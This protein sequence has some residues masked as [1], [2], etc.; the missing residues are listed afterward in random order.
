MGRGFGPGNTQGATKFTKGTGTKVR[1]RGVEEWGIGG[2]ELRVKNLFGPTK[3]DILPVFLTR[4]KWNF[5]E[6]FPSRSNGSLGK[7]FFLRDEARE[8]EIETTRN[9]YQ[10]IGRDAFTAGQKAK[11][12]SEE[13]GRTYVFTEELTSLNFL[14]GGVNEQKLFTLGSGEYISASKPFPS[15]QNRRGWIFNFGSRIQEAQWVPNEQGQTQYLAVAV[16][17]KQ[18]TRKYKHMENPK[19]A[20][21]VATKPFP[22]SIQIWAFDSL[23][24]G[25]LDPSVTPRLEQV[26]CTEWGA[27]KA[28]RW[29]PIGIRNTV[30]PQNDRDSVHL[31]LLAGVWSDGKLRILDVAHQ[32]IRR[33]VQETQ[34]IHYTQAAFEV[35]F[36]ETVPSCIHWLSGTSLAAATASGH[37]AIWSLSRSD[38]FLPAEK[39]TTGNLGPQPWFYRQV[40]DTYIL[41][42]SSGYPSR[43]QYISITTADGF[44][45]LIDLRSPM[46]DTCSSIRGRMLVLTQDWHEHT[47]CFVMPDE[48]Y[49]LTHH[50]IRRYYTNIY[51]MRIESTITACATS[52]VQPCVLLGGADGT[53]MGCN[54]LGKVL[55]TKEI[56]WQQPWFKHEWRPEV[57]QM[58]PGLKNSEGEIDESTTDARH[59]AVE[60]T[61]ATNPNGTVAPASPSRDVDEEPSNDT[62]ASAFSQPLVRITEGY[63]AH[64]T[65]MQYP[66]STKRYKEGAKFITIF[67]EKSA[68]SRLAWNP[69]LKFGAWA[70]AG[71]NSGLL[72]VEDLGV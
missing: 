1:Q 47:Q 24:D 27:P 3:D 65:G 32:Q 54:T 37:V 26:I 20:A 12:L 17:Q 15:D 57:D 13:I 72:R 22:A 35:G 64:Q 10:R 23:E 46:I 66:D 25:E 56:P 45:R 55:N 71:T 9:W 60:P 58:L 29:C 39:R 62:P 48:Y 51:V 21:F 63:K 36:P 61:H 49:M 6:T 11:I 8:K 31:G 53:I 28:L 43:P 59:D 34:Y 50:S 70:V 42:L 33:D 67:E 5:Q 14:M 40:A 2:Q 7:S 69:N 68:I 52:P 19:A 16:E 4:D 30:V 44:A 18:P 38:M 41:T